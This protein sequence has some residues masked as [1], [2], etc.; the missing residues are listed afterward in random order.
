MAGCHSPEL[1]VERAGMGGVYGEKSAG[2]PDALFGRAVVHRPSRTGIDERGDV[3]RQLLDGTTGQQR[4]GV[5]EEL[6]EFGRTRRRTGGVDHER[7]QR[8]GIGVATH[9][10]G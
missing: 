2:G 1:W 4:A 7:G 6:A 8:D 10:E 5:F 3:I 9:L